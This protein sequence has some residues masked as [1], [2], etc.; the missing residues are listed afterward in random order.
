MSIGGVAELVIGLSTI[1]IVYHY[2]AYPTLLERLSRNQKNILAAAVDATEFDQGAALPT[3]TI[4]VP[5]HNESSVIEDKI[6]NISAFDYPAERLK[7][8]IALDGC[9][10]DTRNRAV[11][12][13][14]CA[15]PRLHIEL[16]EYPNNVGKVAVLNEQITRATTEI[17][18]LSDAS[19]IMQADCLRKAIRH[20]ADKS[21]GVVCATYSLDEA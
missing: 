1:V 4:I 21:V 12:A 18:V 13:I 3:I 5:A 7:V 10:D 20:F 15:L 2:F 16:V 9:T 17:I 14:A 11:R 8:I 19:A 6:D